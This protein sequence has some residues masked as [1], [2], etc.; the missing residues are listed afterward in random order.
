[1]KIA[2]VQL[3]FFFAI[4]PSYLDIQRSRSSLQLDSEQRR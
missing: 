2:C 3:T 4:N 1:M